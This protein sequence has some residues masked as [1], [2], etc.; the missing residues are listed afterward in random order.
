MKLMRRTT[1]VLSF[2]TLGVALAPSVRRAEWFIGGYAGWSMTERA[3]V[4]IRGVSVARVPVQASLL[5]VEPEDSPLVG[6]RAGHS[7][8]FLPEV[9]LG[10]DL[11][12]F[13]PDVRRQRVTATAAVSGRT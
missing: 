6:V 10:L 7:F 3:D 5:G 8:G 11:S 1:L 9:G 13:Q 2:T 12:Y 4:D